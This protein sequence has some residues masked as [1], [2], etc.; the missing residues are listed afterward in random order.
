MNWIS[1]HFMSR[2]EADRFFEQ[3]M[4][5]VTKSCCGEVDDGFHCTL[6]K[7]HPDDHEAWVGHIKYHQWPNRATT[8]SH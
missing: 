5:R 7:G 2:D 6:L 4:G 1:T 8:Q 3:S